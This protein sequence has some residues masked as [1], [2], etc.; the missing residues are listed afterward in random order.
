MA[1]DPW[2]AS[3][4]QMDPRTIC[5]RKAKILNPHNSLARPPEAWLPVPHLL[6]LPCF[7]RRHEEHRQQGPK[8]PSVVHLEPQVPAMLPTSPP[9]VNRAMTLL[10]VC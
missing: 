3:G 4:A 1:A 2:T 7:R 9:E 10:R 5:H 6:A 8:G